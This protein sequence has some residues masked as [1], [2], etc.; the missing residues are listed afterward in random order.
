M[1]VLCS[2]ARLWFIKS[3]VLACVR[4]GRQ[5]LKPS[6]SL[7]EF[8]KALVQQLTPICDEELWIQHFDVINEIFTTLPVVATPAPTRTRALNLTLTLTPT[9]T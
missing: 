9:L 2:R 1:Q 3:C 4:V 8:S 6:I 7:R 5:L